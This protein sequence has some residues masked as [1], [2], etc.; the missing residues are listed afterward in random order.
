LEQVLTEVFRARARK[1]APSVV[2]ATVKP[3]D[4]ARAQKAHAFPSE[5]QTHSGCHAAGARVSAR[6][7]RWP[8]IAPRRAP[9]GSPR[10]MRDRTDSIRLDHALLL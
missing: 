9:R 4:A 7:A 1:P 2:G 6:L 5:K 8:R 3:A 10:R